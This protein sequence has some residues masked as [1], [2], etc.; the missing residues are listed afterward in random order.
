MTGFVVQ[1]HKYSNIVE[2]YY[3]LKWLFSIFIY[4]KI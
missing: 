2:Y 1:G 3:N 4:I